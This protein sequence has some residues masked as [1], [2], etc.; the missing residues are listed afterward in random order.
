MRSVTVSVGPLVAAA[1]NNIAL[2]QTPSTTF[3]LNGSLVSGGVATLDTARRVLLTTAADESAKTVII[4]GTDT[5]GSS[6]TEVLTPST[7]AGTAYT[8]LDFKTVTSAR[9]SSAFSGA[10]TLGT[11]GVA[12][13]RWVRMDGWAAPET[14]IQCTVSGTASYTVQSSMQD[15]NDPTSPVL[16][17]LVSW[18]DSPDPNVVAASTTQFSY[19]QFT[20]TWLRVTLNSGTG[21]VSSV[22]GQHG[23]VTY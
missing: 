8:A 12:S 21:S 20:P 4:V 7:G 3:T 5:N 22:I 10:A 6:I 18:I 11:N 17:Y 9:V 23:S 13:S 15:P 2:S 14:N 19:Y 16:P 1:A